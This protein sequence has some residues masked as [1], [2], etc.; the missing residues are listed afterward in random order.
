[1][2]RPSTKV[3]GLAIFVVALF[4]AGVVSFYAASSPDG[5]TK[6]SEDKGFAS[7]Q[8]EHATG[9]GPF[10]GYN[11][12]FIDND[13]LSGGVSGVVGVLTVLL[14]GTGLTYAVRRRRSDEPSNS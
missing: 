13:R 12:N 2:K 5:L 10:A 3:V 1:M 11:S 8:K 4:L 6:V 14:L 7:S 9:E